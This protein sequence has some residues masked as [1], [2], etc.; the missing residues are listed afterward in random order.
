MTPSELTEFVAK[1]D[2]ITRYDYPEDDAVG[3]RNSRLPWYRADK[4]R[5]TVFT[6]DWLADHTEEDLDME[7]KRGLEVEQICR[8]TGYYS[9]VASWNGGKRAELRDRRRTDLYGNPPH[10][11]IHAAEPQTAIAAG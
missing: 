4:D 1:H 3:F 9:K 7:I 8:V 11:A 10:I 6:C 2:Y 5:K